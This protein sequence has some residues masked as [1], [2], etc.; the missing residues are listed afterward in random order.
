[1][2]TLQTG[3][4]SE[5]TVGLTSGLLTTNRL[6]ALAGG[7]ERSC[8]TWDGIRCIG[9]EFRF[10]PNLLDAANIKAPE[11]MQ[12]ESLPLLPSRGLVARIGLLSLLRIS[13]RAYGQ[14]TLC[15]SYK[16]HKLIHYYFATDEWVLIDRRNDLLEQ[17]NFYNDS[18]YAQV[19]A[20]L[21]QKLKALRLK[22]KD[23]DELSNQYIDQ[24][25]SS[26]ASGKVY[27]LSKERARE[28]LLQRQAARANN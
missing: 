6:N 15:H 11:V 2:F 28:I 14:P 17:N 13:R 22:Y 7:L 20:D 16:R 26:A 19:K 18:S 21:H 4:L 12:G 1:M 25:L 5:S 3:Y 10:C 24:F 23:S 8:P 27:G 9:A